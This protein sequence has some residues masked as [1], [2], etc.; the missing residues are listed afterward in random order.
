MD[1]AF[2]SRIHV[3]MAYPDLTAESR[4]QIWKNFLQGKNEISEADLDVLKEIVL[5]GRQIKNV[6][7]TAY[8]LSAR[9]K[10]PL[11]RENIETVLA[12]EGRRPGIGS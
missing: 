7:K 3:S 6:I 2:Q 5:N 12:I 8:L 10:S 11:T 4:R 9:K 1:A